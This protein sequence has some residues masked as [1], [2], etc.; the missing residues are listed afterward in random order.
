MTTIRLTT[1]INASIKNVFDR[2]RD[3]NFHK[4]SASQTQEKVIGGITSGLINK[5][6]TVTWQGKHLGLRLTH[7]SLIT[8]LES[9]SYFVD[10]MVKGN[11]KNFKHE[12]YFKEMGNTTVMTDVL[13]YKVPFSFIG[14]I[15]D[16]LFIKRHLTHFLQIRNQAI[17][18]S[19][20]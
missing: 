11:F 1:K 4:K 5:G 14:E 7:Q 17:K 10:E 15:F 18:N 8:E 3:I 9:P 2:S 16:Y 13:S 6:E 19:F 20:S 12:H